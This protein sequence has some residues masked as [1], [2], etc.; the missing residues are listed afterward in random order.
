M[1][2]P[3]NIGITGHRDLLHYNKGKYYQSL[4]DILNE[5]IKKYPNSKLQLL[6]PLASGA[7][8]L[9]AQ[10]ALELGC[11]I[12]CILPM[13][14]KSYEKDYDRESLQNFKNLLN[15]ADKVIRLPFAKGCN[16]ENTKEYNIYRNRQYEQVGKY[17]VDHSQA[18]IAMWD[19]TDNQKL[20][21]TASV[22]R[23]ALDG[24]DNSTN[25]KK[26]VIPDPEDFYPIFHISVKREK[27][28]NDS[29]TSRIKDYLKEECIG[30]NILYSPYWKSYDG[31][32]IELISS[33]RG[34]F[35]STLEKIDE[36]NVD[37]E[38]VQM[39]FAKD[40]S[41]N[42]SY[43][44]PNE[45]YGQLSQ[46]L[47]NI[48][49]YYAIA[50]TMAQKYQKKTFSVLRWL[51]F[52]GVI[53]FLWAGFYDDIY[54]KPIILLLSPLSF[55]I[56]SVFYM[57]ASKKSVENKFYDYRSLA[58]GLRVH[59]F[60]KVAS[61]DDNVYDFY[62]RKLKGEISWIISGLRNISLI[63]DSSKDL[64]KDNKGL[65][66]SKMYWVQD[67]LKYYKKNVNKRYKDLI[68]QERKT[69]AFFILGMLCIMLMFLVKIELLPIKGIINNKTEGPM[70]FLIDLFFG[71]GAVF[72]G[73]AEKRQFASEYSQF[74]RMASL[75]MRG[76]VAFEK[77]IDENNLEKAYSILKE[78][79]EES[80]QENG[81]WV[82]Y[83]RSNSLEIPMG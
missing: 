62:T 64:K 8:Q 6:T 65:D 56:T 82:I 3:I 4:L 77:A 18:L 15:K 11:S 69:K 17:I 83:N 39:K 73:Y 55:I 2:I 41:K 24:K 67:Q 76:E 57:I 66:I 31:D 59:F 61:M 29:T 60:W 46:G 50:D 78:L 27:Q 81:D 75:F 47:K 38:R 21:G 20:G 10:A 53:T 16:I 7:D 79:G 43:V 32:K 70:F 30:Y 26:S 48:I 68:K 71:V 42:R 36:Y 13:P 37:S 14:I 23:Y 35:E 25:Y 54:Q 40:I 9:A 74:M 49:D 12:I 63:I 51:L 44:I 72:T 33:A 58:E 1:K 80:L 5:I 45:E 34:Y 52:F 28:I 19:G 22:V